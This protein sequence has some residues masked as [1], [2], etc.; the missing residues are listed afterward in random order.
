LAFPAVAG[1]EGVDQGFPGS[2][3][4]IP[5]RDLIGE[6]ALGGQVQTLGAC[7]AEL[8]GDSIYVAVTFFPEDR[9]T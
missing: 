7:E 6:T 4:T 3:L 5:E 8:V 2:P 1:L 9:S